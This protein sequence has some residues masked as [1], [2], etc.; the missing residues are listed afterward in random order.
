M[1]N[2]Q[3]F[4]NSYSSKEIRKDN[5]KICFFDKKKNIKRHKILFIQILLLLV[6]LQTIHSTNLYICRWKILEQSEY[7]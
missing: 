1:K 5:Q 3:N 2:N 4:I 7:I 6:V